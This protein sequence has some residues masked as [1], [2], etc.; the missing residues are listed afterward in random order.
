MSAIP[1]LLPASRRYYSSFFSSKSGGGRYFN[2]AKSPKSPVIAPAATTAANKPSDSSASTQDEG[3]SASDRNAMKHHPSGDG[4]PDPVDGKSSQSSSASPSID[5]G[6]SVGTSELQ[7]GSKAH[8]TQYSTSSTTAGWSLSPHPIVKPKDFRLHQFF[9]LHRPLLLLSNPPSI[10]Y[11]ATSPSPF[12]SGSEKPSSTNMNESE[13]IFTSDT[14]GLP[15]PPPDV[16]SSVSTSPTVSTEYPVTAPDAD[17]E[18]ARLVT[19]ALIM[20]KAG[21]TMAWENTL[22]QLGLD[23]EREPERVEM[24]ERMEREWEKV[25]LD[26]TKRKRG[27]KMKKHKLKKRRKATRATRLKIGR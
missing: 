10:L 17:A 7:E 25:M 20:N 19:R 8:D 9:S 13:A 5:A 15:S 23:V 18:I 4:S 12:S 6:E 2:S 22:R 24:R 21:S 14:T 11:S 27:K 26:S 16:L 3:V 1:R